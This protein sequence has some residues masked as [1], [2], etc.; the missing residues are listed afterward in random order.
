MLS[1]ATGNAGIR[2]AHHRYPF[3]TR[4]GYDA[5]MRYIVGT[6]AQL[7]TSRYALVFLRTTTANRKVMEEALA[8]NNLK[9]VAAVGIDRNAKDFGAGDRRSCS[10]R[11]PTRCCSSPTDRR[12]WRSCAA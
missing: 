12:S 1:P 9:P 5:E 8:A 3:H 4:A 11:S 10:R 7:G 2:L 6:T